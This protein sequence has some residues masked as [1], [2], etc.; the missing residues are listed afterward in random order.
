M[1]R[2]GDNLGSG[3]VTTCTC[4]C[5]DTC[6]KTGCGCCNLA[7]VPSVNTVD[8]NSG[9]G[10]VTNLIGNCYFVGC[11]LFGTGKIKCLACVLIINYAVYL[12]NNAFNIVF[13][14][15]DCN[16]VVLGYTVGV[17][18]CGI[19]L[20]N[21]DHGIGEVNDDL[22]KSYL[23][24]VACV[25]LNC[26]NNG[27]FAVLVGS[28]NRLV[29]GIVCSAY[30]ITFIICNYI[31]D[32]GNTGFG[33]CCFYCDLNA[34][35]III[36]N[37]AVIEICV[38]IIPS[39]KGRSCLIAGNGDN[40]DIGYVACPVGCNDLINLI[41]GCIVCGDDV[42][43]VFVKS[44]LCAVNGN[45]CYTEVICYINCYAS[46]SVGCA[47]DYGRIVVNYDNVDGNR[48]GSITL[49]ICCGSAYDILAFALKNGLVIFVVYAAF[50][51][52]TLF[53]GN[54]IVDMSNSCAVLVILGCYDDNN[55]GIVCIISL[56][57]I[58]VNI[59][60][61]GG[62]GGY[63][64]CAVIFC[65]NAYCCRVACLVGC[66]NSVGLGLYGALGNGYITV[67][68]GSNNGFGTVCYYCNL[69]KV[70]ILYLNLDCIKGLGSFGSKYGCVC[71]N[72]D[73]IGSHCD[74][75]V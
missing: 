61:I 36:I 37:N 7:F 46:V 13:D 23:C 19:P 45:L 2:C 17:I 58:V 65:S 34:A 20:G 4:V 5:H 35:V 33:V 59:N 15:V 38:F 72:N 75:V 3:S 32:L 1:T 40:N 27:I 10:C 63:G 41:L 62:D 18:G 51:Y 70:L 24:Y 22:I 26:Y 25:I 69:V 50:N 67:F 66:C 42:V 73:L 53:V 55:I 44:C 56:T 57:V 6:V 39:L 29:F 16:C 52:V 60:Q 12:N 64:S 9:F 71:I 68:I 31:S 48:L 21:Y 30:L 47:A 11:S 49:L 8:N 28:N 54:Y 43:A 14:N 74:L